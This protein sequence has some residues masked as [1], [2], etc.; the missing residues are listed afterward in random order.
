METI[1]KWKI[2]KV[3]YAEYCLRHKWWIHMVWIFWH[4][5]YLHFPYPTFQ[6]VAFDLGK[7]RTWNVFWMIQTLIQMRL[8]FDFLSVNVLLN[9]VEICKRWFFYVKSKFK[10]E[11]ICEIFTCN[12]LEDFLHLEVLELMYPFWW[13]IQHSPHHWNY[14]Q[15]LK[16]NQD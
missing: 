13:L 12:F 8:N 1:A 10:V 3:R 9:F 14:Q 7:V 4:W 11:F 16:I 5:N 2:F 15:I 6:R